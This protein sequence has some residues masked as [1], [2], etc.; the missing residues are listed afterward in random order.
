MTDSRSSRPGPP[1]LPCLRRL[2]GRAPAAPRPRPMALGHCMRS[3]RHPR[4][5]RST[6][7]RPSRAS[8]WRTAPAPDPQPP[9]PKRPAKKPTRRTGSIQ[10]R[11]GLALSTPQL[12]PPARR[13]SRCRSSGR[14]STAY[15]PQTQRPPAARTAA[16]AQRAR[17]DVLELGGGGP[18]NCNEAPPKRR[19]PDP[20][21]A[22]AVSHASHENGLDVDIRL[23]RRT[24]SRG[25]AHP[26][27]M[28]DREPY[29]AGRGLHGRPRCPVRVRR[30]QP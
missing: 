19:R 28:A 2:G 3:W 9:G 27:R 10:W 7:A 14:G 17:A 21:D 23:P 5:L 13:R 4:W 1:L 25:A 29:A 22:Y 15:D 16:G 12:G 24:A 11:E 30:P 26:T 8:P 18:T 20:E 6:G